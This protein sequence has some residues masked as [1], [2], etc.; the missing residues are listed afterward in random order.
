MKTKLRLLIL[1][2]TSLATAASAHADVPFQEFRMFMPK[3][4]NVRF[5]DADGFA[6][7]P[8]IKS[9]SLRAMS[10]ILEYQEKV[11]TTTGGRLLWIQSVESDGKTYDIKEGYCTL[12]ETGGNAHIV[13]RPCASVTRAQ[14]S[15]AT[16]GF[17][18]TILIPVAECRDQ[19]TLNDRLIHEVDHQR[20]S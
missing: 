15:M 6:W 10:R 1:T 8:R 9:T 17:P 13:V 11:P 7:T 20:R 2:I 19:R 14:T 12:T 5:Q 18:I 3:N 4:L 16:R